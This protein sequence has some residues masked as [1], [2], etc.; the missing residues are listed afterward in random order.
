V[1]EVLII[2][3]FGRRAYID[4]DVSRAVDFEALYN[5]VISP[6][7]QA[8][9]RTPLR[10]EELVTPGNIASQYLNRIVAAD[11]VIADLSMPNGNVYY[12]LG[13]R[14]SLSNRPTILI[15]VHDTV[16]P[17]DLRN[18]RVLL[19]RWST[20]EEVTET[21]KTLDRWIR[22]V[23]AGPYVNP[24]HQYLVGSALSASPADSD[25]FERDL[26][27]KVDRARTPEQLSAVW[28]WA[29]GYDPLPPFA[30]LELANKLAATE[31]WITAATITR[32]ACRAR[33]DDYEIHRMLGWY[34]RKAGEAHY[35]EAERE[36][37]RALEL[38]PG[39]NEAVGMLAGL[40]KRQGEYQRS[41]ELYERGVRAAP[42]NLY[43]RIAQAGVA[44]LS[45]AR[46]DSPA[47]DLY[48][49]VLELCANRPQDAWT[50]V[51][52]A[53]AKFALG[54]LASAA[55]LY[56]QA[57]ALAT[58]PTTLTS[59]A[60]QLE[61]FAEAGFRTRAA[62]D[63]AGRLKGLVGEAA[64][65]VL[66]QPAPAPSVVRS[67][68]L[69]VLVHLSDP[70]FGYKSGAD[71]KRTTMHRF[72]DGDYSL[73]LQEHLRRELGASK[74]R[75][76]LDPANAVIVVSGD[77]VYQAGRDEY[78]DALSFFEGL[79]TDLSIPRERVVF[80]P[81]NHDVN[82]ALSKT[83][84]AER[85]DEY[86]LFLHRFY[87]EALFRQRYPRISWDFTIGSD[88]PA[89][90][91][92]IA[93]ANFTDLG[94][95]IC[96]FNSCVYETHQK[97]YGFI[98]GR[99]TAHAE[100]L[101]SPP[102]GS[103]PVR[104]AVLHHHLHP[105]PEPVALDAE[106]A[107][108]IDASTVRDAGLFEQFLEKNGFDVVLHG[109]KHKPQLRETRV[110]D[111]APGLEPTKSLIVNGGGSCGVEAHEL[112]HGEGNQYSIL[113]FLSPVRTPYADFVRVEWRQLPVTA[114]AEWTTQKTWTLLG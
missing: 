68:P 84:K 58:D 56:D 75:L 11:L 107:H 70:H 10:I 2:M 60:D 73:T 25:A 94:L 52:A 38:N 49:Q 83:D 4:G 41:A 22:D 54:D 48:R 106:G 86:L 31:E 62:R 77:I 20:P 55:S 13:I 63:F 32:A 96:A 53:E 37:S 1:S 66:G 6:G 78:R 91:D 27:G 102:G 72:K 39:D 108:W 17:F 30:L 90:E 50:L 104:I 36:L 5:Q 74:G 85:F 88:R 40:K 47:L 64:G 59:P 16:L 24:V 87:G 101:F 19:Y 69:P 42:T 43:L 57:A 81:G 82:W 71:G 7:V 80:C 109:H 21:I 45:D 76:R 103:T 89:P 110:R 65:K 98:G 100:A 33:P 93:V 18:Q 28:A 105:Y 14:Q 46:E 114:G 67:G 79:V 34:L 44:L 111:G 51:A 9:G 26:R 3:P 97:H 99:Q 61:L 112:E 29:S 95:E 12:E 8:A 113:E 35:D 15:A 23:D 92:L